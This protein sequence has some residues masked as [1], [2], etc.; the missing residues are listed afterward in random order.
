MV[1]QGLVRVLDLVFV[2]KQPDGEL[3]VVELDEDE[4]GFGLREVVTDARELINDEDIPVGR[5]AWMTT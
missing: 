4:E 2:A 5:P 3:R 1:S